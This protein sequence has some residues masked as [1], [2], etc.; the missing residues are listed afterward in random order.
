MTLAWARAMGE[1][2][3]ILIFAGTT[4]M[5]TEV[6]STTVFLEMSVGNLES[7]LAVSLLMVGL[8]LIVL[9][10]VRWFGDGNGHIHDRR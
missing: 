9:M 1:F 6:M 5:R 2:G 8:A 4:R 3:P 7:A 10:V